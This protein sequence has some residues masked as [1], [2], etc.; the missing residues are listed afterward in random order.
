META[1]EL[2]SFQLAGRHR[3]R[4]LSGPLGHVRTVREDSRSLETSSGDN[5]LGNQK[6]EKLERLEG[7]INQLIKEIRRQNKR[8]RQSRGSP[9]RAEEFECWNCGEVGRIARN[10]KKPAGQEGKNQVDQGRIF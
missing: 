1:S 9:P 3:N 5:N 7:A 4:F 10:C 2:E 8:Q 6:D